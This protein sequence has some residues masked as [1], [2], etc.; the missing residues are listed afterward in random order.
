MVSD[1]EIAKLW[2]DPSFPGSYRGAR[3]F[4]VLLKTDLNIDISLSRIYKILNEDQIYLIHKPPK[5][6]FLRR[7]YVVHNYGELCQ[8]D[9]AFMFPDGEYK[10]F[11]LL[12][13]VFS[14][15]VFTKALKSRETNEV[16]SALDKIIDEFQS[17][18]YEIQSDK[19]SAFI[20][21]VF[22]EYLQQKKIVFRLKSGKNKAAIAEN[23]ILIL[24]R[25]L[26]MQLRGTLDNKWVSALP[27]VTRALNNTPIKRLGIV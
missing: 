11:L 9:I 5:R 3:T 2:R 8:M 21:K 16:K 19:E 15:K 25:K 13:D 27:I 14:S 26:Y 23:Y 7:S 24:K 10:Y 22:K 18:I 12:V 20:S 17:Q 4:Q 6:I 1:E